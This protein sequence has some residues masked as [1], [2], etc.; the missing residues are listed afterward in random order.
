MLVS[1][2]QF[3]IGGDSRTR[4]EVI[5]K[6]FRLLGA[7]E[8]QGFG[9]PL[10]FKTAIQNDFRRPEI[11]SDLQRTES[12]VWNIDLADSYPELPYEKKAGVAINCKEC[13]RYIYKQHKEKF[14]YF[15]LQSPKMCV[16]VRWKK[17]GAKRGKW[18]FN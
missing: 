16:V 7:S 8:R 3:V 14:G 2:E 15:R 5:M 10:I 18:A 13:P 12:K 9:G 6:L 1:K 11:V 4:N 17:L